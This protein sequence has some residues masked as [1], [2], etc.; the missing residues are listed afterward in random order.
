M[1][2]LLLVCPAIIFLAGF[3]APTLRG[4][5][6]DRAGYVLSLAPFAAFG[7]ILSQGGLIND[8]EVLHYSF[9][10][11]SSLGAS[12]DFRLDGLAFLMAILITGIGGFIVI[13]AQ[14]YMHGHPNLGRFFLYLLSFMAAMLESR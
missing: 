13:Y 7:L 3:I 8:G 10:W 9:E 6:G 1:S 2:E 14:G 4:L 12:L 11:F 5:L